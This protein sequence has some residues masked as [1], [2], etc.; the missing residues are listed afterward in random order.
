[1]RKSVTV[2][3]SGEGVFVGVKIRDVAA[4]AG[5]S[6]ATASRALSGGRDVRPENRSRVLAAARELGYRPDIV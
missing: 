6:V 2:R 5:V 3:C 1:M 4:R